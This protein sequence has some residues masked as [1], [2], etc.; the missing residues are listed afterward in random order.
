MRK[1]FSNNLKVKKKK[2]K[3]I[4]KDKNDLIS[5]IIIENGELNY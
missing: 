4:S 2:T 5:T 1:E 3:M